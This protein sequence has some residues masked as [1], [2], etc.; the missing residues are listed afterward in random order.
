MWQNRGKEEKTDQARMAAA[1]HL[2]ARPRS[3][4][5]PESPQ[6]GSMELGSPGKI[7][8]HRLKMPFLLWS[9]GGNGGVWKAVFIILFPMAR[10]NLREHIVG[11][12][13]FFNS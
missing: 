1:A 10:E 7:G 3:S 5:P 9:T 13:R 2:K 11:K 8:P 4:R 6:G 12:I